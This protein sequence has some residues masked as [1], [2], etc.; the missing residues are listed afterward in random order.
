[1]VETWNG[2]Y[3]NQSAAN[4][5]FREQF[6]EIKSDLGHDWYATDW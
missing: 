3:F 1:M 5:D 2:A 6:V 4:A